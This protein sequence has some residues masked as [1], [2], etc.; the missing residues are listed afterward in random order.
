MHQHFTHKRTKIS[1]TQ[2]RLG[3]ARTRPAPLS[4]AWLR[5]LSTPR[6]R[7]CSNIRLL[8]VLNSHS[9]YDLWFS[10]LLLLSEWLHDIFLSWFVKL[11]WRLLKDNPV[12]FLR[13]TATKHN[14]SFF[15]S[16]FRWWGRG[17][18]HTN[19]RTQCLSQSPS[20]RGSRRKLRCSKRLKN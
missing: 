16:P 3:S 10:R 5:Q 13:H 20:H 19:W 2:T 18:V 6:W 9:K 17:G 7:H 15:L 14:S 4:L 1:V 11:W 8:R 12:M